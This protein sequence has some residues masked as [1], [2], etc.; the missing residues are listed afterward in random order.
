MVAIFLPFFTFAD[1]V[2]N[3]ASI[4]FEKLNFFAELA[5]LVLLNPWADSYFSLP[6][7]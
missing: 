6:I 4:R 7:M 1:H 3:I 5:I 2:Q